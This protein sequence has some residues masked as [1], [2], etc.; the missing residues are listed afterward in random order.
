MGWDYQFVVKSYIDIYNR[1]FILKS[2]I[3]LT[4]NNFVFDDDCHTNYTKV[5]RTS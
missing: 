2:E 1:I 5:L 4:R 3:I